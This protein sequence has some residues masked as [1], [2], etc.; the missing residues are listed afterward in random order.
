MLVVCP[1]KE[2]KCYNNSCRHIKPHKP[3]RN[4]YGKSCSVDWLCGVGQ[5]LCLSV[6][7]D[8]DKKELDG[9]FDIC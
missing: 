6:M 4:F 7:D 9:I 1:N 5:C 3:G 2:C 8:E